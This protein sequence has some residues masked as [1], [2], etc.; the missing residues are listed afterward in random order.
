MI[1]GTGCGVNNDSLGTCGGP[2]KY[3]HSNGGVIDGTDGNEHILGDEKVLVGSEIPGVSL[4]YDG[5]LEIKVVAGCKISVDNRS[6]VQLTRAVG[7]QGCLR[8]RKPSKVMLAV[9]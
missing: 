9:G 4:G 1:I 8:Q 7:Q 2:K 5:I 6:K 3:K